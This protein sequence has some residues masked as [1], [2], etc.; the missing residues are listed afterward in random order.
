MLKEAIK[1]LDA[2][3]SV[4]PVSK[5]KTPLIKW[6][7]FQTRLPSY[8][9]VQKWW[10]D[11]PEANI[12]VATGV[13]SNL[14]VIDIDTDEGKEIIKE[15]IPSDLV[16]P[17]VST[18]KGGTH[19]W[20]RCAD[21]KLENNTRA[22]PGIDFRA[23]G[24]YVIVPPSANGNGRSYN[25]DISF[26]DVDLADVPAEYL[27]KIQ[28]QEKDLL[29]LKELKN[30]N[31][32]SLSEGS[33]NEVLFH[34]AYS[35]LKGGA[36]YS[37][38]R[39]LCQK[40]GS[41]SGL[42]QSE[43]T[44]IFDSAY[45]RIVRNDRNIHQEIK[46][47]IKLVT[48]STFNVTDCY[49][50]LEIVTKSDRAAARQALKRLVE[51]K[52]I[53]SEGKRG[54]YKPVDES[55]EYIDI[56][57]AGDA[58]YPLTLPMDIHKYYEAQDGN[59]IIVSGEQNAGKTAWCL[60]AMEMNHMQHKVCYM[61]SEMSTPEF[62]K[63]I[64]AF[65]MPIEAWNWKNI[66]LI[67]RNDNFADL[68]KPDGR[69]YICDFIEVYDDFYKV[70]ATIRDIW[71]ALDGKGIAICCL[72]KNAGSL[73]GRGGSFSAEK[74]RLVINLEKSY[75]KVGNWCKIIKCKNWAPDIID[76]PDGMQRRYKLVHG[77]KFVESA[78]AP[79]ESLWHHPE[80]ACATGGKKIVQVPSC[81]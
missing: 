79:T 80:P 60:S 27:N 73:Y 40:V 41:E 76:N 29:S 2:G 50:D 38:V 63:R 16:T 57:S 18:P 74:A 5:D 49:R 35:T 75:D 13:V 22:L 8:E 62:K 59:V 47:W 77:N 23:N 66:E 3:L 71:Q 43:I 12:G 61:S 39:G 4:I 19:Y 9:E 72:Q 6:K 52:L 25:F 11:H 24:G 67:N 55:I 34:L 48:N 26:F 46:D 1:Y 30:L 81:G 14:A 53:R 68:I 36:S 21:P 65:D 45:Q 44:K 54:L 31:S 28:H 33:R 56:F 70:G 64:L 15:Y 58:G 10:T 37:F 7:E 32:F 42:N 20:F 17:M 78:Q 51:D 69:I